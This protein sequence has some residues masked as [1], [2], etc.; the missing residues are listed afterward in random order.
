MS[1]T[2]DETNAT[3]ALIRAKLEGGDAAAAVTEAV[4]VFGPEMMRYLF[5]IH[6]DDDDADDA[7]SAFAEQLWRW[8]PKFRWDC[9]LRS[10]CYRLARNASVDFRRAKG[11][12]L[13][14]G[15][16]LSDCPD[17][18]RMAA[19]VRTATLS[20]LRT[21]ARGAL[22]DLRR[23]LSHDDQTLLILRLEQGLAWA[24]LARVFLDGTPATDDDVR[25]ESARLRKRFQL[26]KE[27]LKA[28]GRK[29][30]LL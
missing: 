9:A 7:F 29:R 1:A 8:L 28:L 17:V 13:R 24:E 22:D 23:S 2:A 25:R 6:R 16:P 19:E 20:F 26:V 15:V 21:D 30:G 11:A 4:R 18:A 3:E 12:V 27:Q 10:F 14:L 5:A